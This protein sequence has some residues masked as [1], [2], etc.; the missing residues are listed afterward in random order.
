MYYLTWDGLQGESIQGFNDVFRFFQ[1]PHSAQKQG[2]DICFQI[3]H[4][5]D[6]N[7]RK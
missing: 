2:D 1:A 6:I 5:H 7:L 4:P 3:S